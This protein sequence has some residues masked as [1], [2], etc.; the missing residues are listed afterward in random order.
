MGDTD[1]GNRQL[2]DGDQLHRHYSQDA[3]AW[4]EA[5]ENAHVPMV[6][7]IKLYRDY[8]FVSDFDRNI[9]APLFGPIRRCAFLHFRWR[10]QSNDVY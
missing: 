9:G 4:Y 7:I 3:C 1:F 6:R 5:D 2:N 8:L 10:R